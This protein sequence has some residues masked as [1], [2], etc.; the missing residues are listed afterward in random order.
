[1]NDIDSSPPQDKSETVSPAQSRSLE[2][3]GVTLALQHVGSRLSTIE[4]QLE[5]V[6]A[7][8]IG[9]SSGAIVELL[10]IA[11]GGWPA[12]GF[13]FLLLFYTPLRDALN[14]IPEKVRA[15]E[16][17]GVLG[18]SLKSTIK[19]EAAR[20]GASSLSE[21]I[22]TL[23]QAAIEQLLKAPKNPESLISYTPNSK[24]EYET[25]HFPSVLLV[26]ALSELQAKGLVAIATD[27][28]GTR[29]LNGKQLA[30]LVQS[31]RDMHPGREDGSFSSGRT[32]WTPTRP[33]PRDTRI[34]M[35]TWEPTDLGKKA[36][37]VVLRAVATEL[38]PKPASKAK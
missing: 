24:Q 32:S 35:L 17:I 25:F 26:E 5:S 37:D 3:L 4:R 13:I 22:P 36:I 9:K 8:P 19:I 21:T 27:P 11:F 28:N 15:A 14:A 6:N 18:V 16:E 23:S 38:A 20:L 7:R 12:L 29:K 1:M 31:F 2:T 34:P 33:L 10:K 30:D